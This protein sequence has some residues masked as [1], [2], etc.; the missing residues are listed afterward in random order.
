MRAQRVDEAESSG[1]PLRS[2]S[3]GRGAAHD[4]VIGITRTGADPSSEVTRKASH[5][6]GT[7]ARGL[8]GLEAAIGS[9]AAAMRLRLLLLLLVSIA[10]GLVAGFVGKATAG[11]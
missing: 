3:S 4:D 8:R 9:K 1:P 6:R 5:V 2:G 10:S 7:L 11:K